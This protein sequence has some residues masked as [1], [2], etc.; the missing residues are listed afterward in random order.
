MEEKQKV[1]FSVIAFAA[2]IVIAV[3]IY[4]LLIRDKVPEKVEEEIVTQE[5]EPEVQ[6][7]P[8]EVTKPGLEPLY[9]TL[10]E[11]DPLVR[12]KASGISDKSPFEDW[13]KT[14][15]II[16][17]FVAAVDNIAHGL[18]PR[19]QMD[20]FNLGEEFKVLE[21]EEGWIVDPES[22]RRYDPVVQ[23]FISLDIA[24]SV[25]L[26]YQFQPAIQSAYEKLGYPEQDFTNTL[27]R[28]VKELMAVP[29]VTEPIQLEQKTMSYVMTDP[30]L[31]NLSAARKHLL[32]MGPENVRKVQAKLNEFQQ[33]LHNPE[34]IFDLEITQ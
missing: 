8:E 22:Y 2:L 13:L 34:E 31:E 3:G 26:Y 6:T 28:A 19:A 7:K 9:V 17:K 14:E 20:F 15:N 23:V 12:E 11:S 18:S 24:E 27:D 10:E 21:T 16:R 33:A 29:V 5:L 32:R 4:F 25:K 30:E 1:I